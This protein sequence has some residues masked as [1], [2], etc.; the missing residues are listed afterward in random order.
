[1]LSGTAIGCIVSAGTPDSSGRTFNHTCLLP[2]EC[3]VSVAVPWYAPLI[4]NPPFI[5]NYV[6]LSVI[7]LEVVVRYNFRSKIYF[8]AR[9]K[10]NKV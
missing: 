2:H 8:P 1:M 10:R 7:Q 4:H 5:R 3:G 9:P 6:F